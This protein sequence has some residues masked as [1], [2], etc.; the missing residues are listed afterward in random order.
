MTWYK[1]LAKRWGAA[2]LLFAALSACTPPARESPLAME[3]V[4]SRSERFLRAG[5][6]EPIA[7]EI[8]NNT[9]VNVEGLMTPTL[10][11]GFTSEPARAHFTVAPSQTA[12]VAFSVLA[13]ADLPPGSYDL[14]TTCRVGTLTAKTPGIVLVQPITWEYAVPDSNAWTRIPPEA[15]GPDGFITLPATTLHAR[16][17]IESQAPRRIRLHT[18]GDTSMSLSLNGEELD[19]CGRDPDPKSGQVILDARLNEGINRIDLTSSNEAGSVRFY[20]RLSEAKR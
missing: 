16:A 13:P 3:L 2:V 19:L 18:G 4:D 20:L 14:R 11:T 12:R 9:P 10:P 15:L 1:T 5:Q 7:Y 8:R 17:I 6:A